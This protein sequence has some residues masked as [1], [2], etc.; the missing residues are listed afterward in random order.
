MYA[1]RQIYLERDEQPGANANFRR[2][3]RRSWPNSRERIRTSERTNLETQPSMRSAWLTSLGASSRSTCR[4]GVP[5][6]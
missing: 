5:L 4:R 6:R 2:L 1:T 3:N